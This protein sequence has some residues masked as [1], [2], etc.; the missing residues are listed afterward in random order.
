MG[1]AKFEDLTVQAHITHSA[2]SAELKMQS[3]YNKVKGKT[4]TYLLVE[5]SDDA[6]LLHKFVHSSCKLVY[7]TPGSYTTS[8]SGKK[9]VI[10][11]MKLLSTDTTVVAIV[12]QDFDGFLGQTSYPDRVFVTD[13]HDLDVMV[14]KAKLEDGTILQLATDSEGINIW[15]EKSKHAECMGECLPEGVLPLGCCRLENQINWERNENPRWA[16]SFKDLPYDILID[17]QEMRVKLDS[18]LDSL[19][20]TR[21]V[22]NKET[23]QTR[24]EAQLLH[25]TNKCR[26]SPQILWQICQGHD[27]LRFICHFLYDQ[28]RREETL[29]KHLHEKYSFAEWKRTRLFSE[30]NKLQETHPFYKIWV[31]V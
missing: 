4:R 26:T 11:T 1:P 29:R 15:R 31:G 24:V 27:L 3:N 18:L 25:V 17:R 6:K 7:K 8:L 20:A 21:S 2:L 30:I 9:F 12:D 19:L 13:E 28:P 23:I 22:L 16:F 10:E 5:G 14:C